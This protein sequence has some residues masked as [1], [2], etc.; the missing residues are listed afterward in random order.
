V[1]STNLLEVVEIISDKL[2]FSTNTSK[3]LIA[4]LT[5]NK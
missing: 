2:I 3:Q 5:S 1:K 4:P